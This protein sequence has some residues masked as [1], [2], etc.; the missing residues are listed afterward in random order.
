MIASAGETVHTGIIMKV[1]IYTDGA[2][3]GNQNKNNTGGWGA[4]LEYG[5]H[6]KELCGGGKDTTNNRMEMTALLEAFRALKKQG[7]T[8]EVFSDSSY[9]MNCFRDKWYKKWKANG[10]MTRAGKPVENRDLW[11]AL[12]P[13]TEINDISFF[14]VKGHVD[15]DDQKTDKDKLYRAF[16]EWNGSSFSAEDFEY[17]TRMNC[18]ADQLANTGMD[19]YR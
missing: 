13:F 15:L 6:R 1:R 17:I 5:G 4:I 3:S 11:E 19:G 16:T 12:L 10:W 14:R 18:R 8:I 7:L 2:C 9:L